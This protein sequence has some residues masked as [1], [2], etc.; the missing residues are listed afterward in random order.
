MVNFY[1][2]LAIALAY[3][4]VSIACRASEAFWD[5]VARCVAEHGGI[6]IHTDAL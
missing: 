3:P 1:A 5:F 4:V 2:V 6:R